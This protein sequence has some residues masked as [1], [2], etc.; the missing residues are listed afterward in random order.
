MSPY[1]VQYHPIEWGALTAVWECYIDQLTNDDPPTNDNFLLSVE[2]CLEPSYENLSLEQIATR[3]RVH[4]HN[5]WVDDHKS[6]WAKEPTIFWGSSHISDDD[7]LQKAWDKDFDAKYF[8]NS[9]GKV[10]II[11]SRG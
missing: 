10:R 5:Q 3:Q 8:P 7:P 6:Q 9:Y 4:E 1:G 2:R 11:T